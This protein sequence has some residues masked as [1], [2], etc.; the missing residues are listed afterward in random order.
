MYESKATKKATSRPRRSKSKAG[1]SV[2]EVEDAKRK[3]INSVA[4]MIDRYLDSS[5]SYITKTIGALINVKDYENVKSK[6][7]EMGYLTLGELLSDF[8]KLRITILNK[9]R[10]YKISSKR[11]VKWIGACFRIEKY[12]YLK[13]LMER[14]GYKKLKELLA[15]LLSDKLIRK[16]EKPSQSR[17][18]R[19]P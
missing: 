8:M 10:T 14:F 1:T 7:S 2:I 18:E 6:L 5:K 12:N 11:P 4:R 3:R 17:R 15:D 9:P 19:S 16:T 13:W